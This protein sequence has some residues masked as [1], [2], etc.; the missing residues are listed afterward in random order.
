MENTTK[1]YGKALCFLPFFCYAAWF[2]YFLAVVVTP[3]SWGNQIGMI[4]NMMQ[5]Y[6]GLFITLALS[7][8]ITATILVYFIVHIARLQEMETLEKIGWI[9]FMTFLAPV[10]FIV[11]WYME[12]SLEPENIKVHPSIT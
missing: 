5:N 6:G 10:A 4:T 1:K 8:T 7:T 12:L 9:V 3:F 11:F 2:I